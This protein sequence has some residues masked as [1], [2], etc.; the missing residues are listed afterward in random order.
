MLNP[1]VT[2]S[3]L[4]LYCQDT[5]MDDLLEPELEMIPSSVVDVA[6]QPSICDGGNDDKNMHDGD[7]VERGVPAEGE[8]DIRRQ[9]KMDSVSTITSLRI[10]PH[11]LSRRKVPLCRLVPMPMVRPTLSCDLTKLEQEFI[12]GYDEGARVF[13]ASVSNE[14]G[15]SGVFSDAEKSEWGPHWKRINDEF[16]LELSMHPELKHLVDAKFFLCDGNHRRIAWMRHINR[17][18]SADPIWHISVDTILLETKGRLGVAMQVM[19]D[20]NK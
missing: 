5:S 1:D 20:I 7:V 6:E 19:H 9:Q 13:Y 15:E 14:Q 10:T 12:H 16:N 3:I 4:L 11:N 2:P 18:H 17:M 8:D